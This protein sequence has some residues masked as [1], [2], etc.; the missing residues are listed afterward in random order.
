MSNEREFHGPNLAYMLGLRERFRTDPASL[1]EAT[2]QYFE[3]LEKDESEPVALQVWASG[4][5]SWPVWGRAP[6][7]R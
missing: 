2:R 7:S 1:D 3:R 4:G 6:G 5:I